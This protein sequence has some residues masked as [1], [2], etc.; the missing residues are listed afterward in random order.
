MRISSSGITWRAC[1]TSRGKAADAGEY[2]IDTMREYDEEKQAEILSNHV[3]AVFDEGCVGRSS[4][5]I[6]MTG[7]RTGGRLKIGRLGW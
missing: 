5:A 7:S 1:R 3:K 6:R 2:G 4:S